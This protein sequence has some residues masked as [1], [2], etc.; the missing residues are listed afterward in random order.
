MAA[1]T[2]AS[3]SS[4]ASINPVG[5]PPAMT[6]ACSVMN[7]PSIWCAVPRRAGESIRVSR[8]SPL[9]RIPPLIRYCSDNELLKNP[10]YH[11][12][13]ACSS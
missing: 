5:P 1:S 4:A 12:I 9:N 11:D 2:P 10:E 3:A 7:P 13:L 8:G 6:T